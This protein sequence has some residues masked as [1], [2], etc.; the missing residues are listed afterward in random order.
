LAKGKRVLGLTV[1]PLVDE[2]S[3]SVIKKMYLENTGIM[4]KTN[5]QVMTEVIAKVRVEADKPRTNNLNVN[6]N[7]V[8][9]LTSA[10]SLGSS[11]NV[12]VSQRS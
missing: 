3:V 1:K 8:P 4:F 9:F 2:A 10:K 5:Q 7:G 12:S 11:T 6:K